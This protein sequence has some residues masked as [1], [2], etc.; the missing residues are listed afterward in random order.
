MLGLYRSKTTHPWFQ[1]WIA[2]LLGLAAYLV[3]TLTLG[4]MAADWEIRWLL[5]LKQ[6]Q[7]AGN[8]HKWIIGWL[9]SGVITKE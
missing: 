2:C 7:C 8:D 9:H 6:K 4:F 3:G 5:H 1:R